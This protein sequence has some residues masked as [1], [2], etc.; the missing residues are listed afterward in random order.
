MIN[1]P[2]VLL[3][4]ISKFVY[5]QGPPGIPGMDG[6]DGDKGQIGKQGPTVSD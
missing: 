2:F 6:V 1:I 3:Q 5:S 4:Y